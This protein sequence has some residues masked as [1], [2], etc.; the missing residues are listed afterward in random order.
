M[1]C[2]VVTFGC[3]DFAHSGSLDCFVGFGDEIGAALTT[4]LMMD[5]AD[6]ENSSES[7]IGLTGLTVASSLMRV[8]MTK[9]TTTM[10]REMRRWRA[11]SL[12]LTRLRGK[13]SLR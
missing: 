10:R 7:R 9:R 2:S 11:R 12:R 4:T 5:G 6:F 13:C 1:T 8:T 3:F